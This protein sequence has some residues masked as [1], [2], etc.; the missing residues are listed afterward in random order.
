MP[1]VR[2]YVSFY[3]YT[4]SGTFSGVQKSVVCFSRHIL[5][6]DMTLHASCGG[7]CPLGASSHLLVIGGPFL[8]FGIWQIWEKPVGVQKLGGK[9]GQWPELGPWSSVLCR[10]GFCLMETWGG[11]EK[12]PCQPVEDPVKN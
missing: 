12:D 5:S 4:L 8:R 11:Q 7:P 2:F 1:S 10:A 6:P 3:K 9:W